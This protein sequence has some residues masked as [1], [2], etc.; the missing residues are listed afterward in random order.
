[1][2]L[3]RP[4]DY[5]QKSVFKSSKCLTDD[6]WVPADLVSYGVHGNWGEDC[7]SNFLAAVFPV[8]LPL[9]SA[10]AGPQKWLCSP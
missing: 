9:L 10:P 1:M 7:R 2:L 5:Q 3:S 8:I 4:L 6:V